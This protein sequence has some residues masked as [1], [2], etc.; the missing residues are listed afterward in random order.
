MSE[1]RESY[2]LLFIALADPVFAFCKKTNGSKHL[3]L[4]APPATGKSTLIKEAATYPGCQFY[5]PGGKAVKDC[6]IT[7]LDFEPETPYTAEHF[8]LL[9]TL[10]T[11]FVVLGC[12]PEWGGKSAPFFTQLGITKEEVEYLSLIQ[13]SAEAEDR[14]KVWLTYR[15]QCRDSQSHSLTRALMN[16]QEKKG[17]NLSAFVRNV[18]FQHP[19]W[20]KLPVFDKDLSAGILARLMMTPPEISGDNFMTWKEFAPPTWQGV[21]MMPSAPGTVAHKLPDA[22]KILTGCHL[23]IQTKDGKRIL[24]DKDG[25][26][27]PGFDFNTALYLGV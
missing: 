14:I 6:P 19:G 1:N 12:S 5:T 21:G 15:L 8:K 11:S 26:P 3:Y 2:S 4:V 10:K 20:R 27:P 22:I 23:F 16:D 17:V 13:Y 9:R 24:L 25:N 18:M 7:F